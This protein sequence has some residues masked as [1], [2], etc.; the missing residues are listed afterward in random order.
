[1]KVND[2]SVNPANQAPQK[3]RW[4]YLARTMEA[5]AELAQYGEEGWELVSVVPIPHD[6]SQA[7][8]HFKRRRF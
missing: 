8:F 7:V 2:K 1:M 6:P 3:T 5:G 4:E